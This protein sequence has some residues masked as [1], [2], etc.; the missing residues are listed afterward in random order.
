MYDTL[1]NS[2]KNF[3]QKDEKC[4]YSSLS[5]KKKRIWKKSHLRNSNPGP[6]DYKDYTFYPL[7]F[8]TKYNSYP[9]PICYMASV[10]G[11]L[12]T[13][14]SNHINA[15]RLRYFTQ[16]LQK[17]ICPKNIRNVIFYSRLAEY[18]FC[19]MYWYKSRKILEFTL[20]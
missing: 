2:C 6:L 8:F 4:T 14:T 19:R 3:L 17:K 7:I 9:Y 16:N 1:S 12:N 20:P 18:V 13:S 15:V 5:T 11:F 10:R